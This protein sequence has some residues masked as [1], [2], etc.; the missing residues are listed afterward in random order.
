MIDLKKI[1]KIF[2][3]I[4]PLLHIPYIRKTLKSELYSF[5]TAKCT[6]LCTALNTANK[7]IRA[8]HK[9][10]QDCS[11]QDEALNVPTAFYGLW[12]SINNI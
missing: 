7:Y 2:K 8:E 5:K 3:I 10:I 6:V 12:S 11:Y 4:D 9:N 1:D